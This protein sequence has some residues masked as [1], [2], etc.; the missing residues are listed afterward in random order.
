VNQPTFQTSWNPKRQ[1]VTYRIGKQGTTAFLLFGA[2][3]ITELH[4]QLIKAM[5]GTTDGRLRT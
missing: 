1:E 2:D 4:Q 3:D 5:K